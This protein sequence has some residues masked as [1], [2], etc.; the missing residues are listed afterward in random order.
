MTKV[1]ATPPPQTIFLT[2]DELALRYR[3]KTQTLRKWRGEG[4]GPRFTKLGSRVVYPMDEVLKWDAER[5]ISNTAQGH[6]KMIGD[7]EP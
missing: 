7:R 4:K 6:L 2:T 3:V 1:E 5:T